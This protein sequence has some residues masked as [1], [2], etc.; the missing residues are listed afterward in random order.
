MKPICRQQK[1]ENLPFPAS[2]PLTS[3]SEIDENFLKRKQFSV[4]KII[5]C[6][7]PPPLPKK[8]REKGKREYKEAVVQVCGSQ[9]NNEPEKGISILSDK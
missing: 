4:S 8:K 3:K 2:I 9:Q 6:T 7:P 5:C 1:Y